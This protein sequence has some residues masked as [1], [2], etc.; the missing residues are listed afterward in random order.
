MGLRGTIEIDP[1]P[2]KN[3]GDKSLFFFFF[4]F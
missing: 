2:P 1:L 3:E 4:F